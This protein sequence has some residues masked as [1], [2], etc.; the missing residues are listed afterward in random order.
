MLKKIRK[1]LI[2]K[3]DNP[4]A[5]L[6]ETTPIYPPQ[7]ELL[8][9]I[10]AEEFTRINGQFIFCEDE[11]AFQSNLQELISAKN[12]AHVYCWERPL[13]N[14]LNKAQ[15]IH[16]GNDQGFID[17]ADVGITLCD[18][19]AARTASIM[20]GSGNEAGRRLSVY[21]HAHVVVAYTSQL[22][23]DIKE[24]LHF[25]KQ[26]YEGKIPSMISNTTGPSRTADIEKTLVLGAH[27]PKEIFCFLIDDS[28]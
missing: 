20:V 6:E 10:F 17:H 1:A 27:G 7:D 24:A 25:I 14:I 5:K 12:W 9:L 18:A 28:Q 11:N 19:I 2:E 23:P 21:P 22:Y 26:K 13:Q 15:I 16:I 3:R 4:Y 8:E